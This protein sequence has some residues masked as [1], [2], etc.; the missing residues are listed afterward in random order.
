MLDVGRTVEGGFNVTPSLLPG[1]VPNGTPHRSAVVGVDRDCIRVSLTCQTQSERNFRAATCQPDS[2]PFG[3]KRSSRL[4]PT[5]GRLR[6]VGS[7]NCRASLNKMSLRISAVSTPP[8]GKEES[9]TA[10]KT[11]ANFFSGFLQLDPKSNF[12]ASLWQKRRAARQTG[13]SPKMF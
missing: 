4:A 6:E 9:C 1:F 7:Y 3:D 2:S 11:L 10:D 8:S 13:L 5:R 12:D